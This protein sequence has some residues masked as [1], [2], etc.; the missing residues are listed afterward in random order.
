MSP[1][2]FP[3]LRGG[4]DIDDV[5]K[6][7]TEGRRLVISVESALSKFEGHETRYHVRL[8]IWEPFPTK[9]LQERRSVNAALHDLRKER[10]LRRRQ[11]ALHDL[12]GRPLGWASVRE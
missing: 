3:E 9:R 12:N 5:L 6:L 4:E 11:L 1:D 7:A 10:D 2:A 8:L